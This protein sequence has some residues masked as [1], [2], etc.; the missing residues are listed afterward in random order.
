MAGLCG[1]VGDGT[2]DLHRVAAGL[3]WTG[4]EAT[5]AFDDGD[6]AVAG[7]FT[8]E[9]AA[10]QPVEVD[11]EAYLWV[12]GTIFGADLDGG[13][14]SRDRTAASTAAYCARLYEAHGP[15]FVA[16]LNGDF[17]LVIYRPDRGTL[18]IATDRLG[19][20]DAYYARPDDDTLVFSTAIQSLSRHPAV[21]PAF[22]ADYA[23][24]Y[25]ACR[26]RTFGVRTPLADTRM[27]HPGATTSI[28][29]AS[30]RLETDR[31]WVPR[32][33]PVDRPFSEF[34]EEFTERFEAAVADRL[35]PSR[36]HG[37]LL[38]GGADSRLVLAAMD[39][40]D[41]AHTTAFT[42]T[43]WMNREAR[44][45]ERV[46][47]TADV[48]FEWIRR[49]RDYH[50]RALERNP[51]LSNFVG[52]FNQAHAEGVM[53][54][55][56]PAVDE[57][58][59][60]SF[61]DTNVDGY[62]FPRRTVRLGPVGTIYLPAFE[63][64]DSVD[65]YVDTW[66]GDPPEYLADDVDVE[67]VLRREIRRTGDG[68]DHH[69]VT[70]GSPKELFVCGALAPRTNGTVLSLLHGLRQHVP[71]WSPFVDDRLVDLYLS[72]PTEYAAGRNVVHRAIERL[73][74]E[75]AG[76][77]YANTG[78]PIE[79]PFVAHF[80]GGMGLRF[81]RSYLPVA[82]PPEPHQ[83]QGSWPDLA[84]LIRETSFVRESIEGNE[85]TIRR[86]PF[87]DWEGVRE[88]YRDHLSGNDRQQDLYA[89]VTLLEM[90]VTGRVVE[91]SDRSAT[92]S[93]SGRD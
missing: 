22:D 62:S 75:L 9:A 63:P 25:L 90:P 49:D 57:V 80:L 48:D 18:A 5:T 15:G 35:H 68:I 42:V 78:V 69:G 67:A 64:M 6:V 2:Q 19:L 11:G 84:E 52:R 27:F 61:A 29:T 3:E 21:T 72:M 24:E 91:R 12:W 53:D 47:A 32:Y 33:R 37:L 59:T 1:V 50:A 17:L 51:A 34:V 8:D 55:I 82:E 38:S 16:G 10:D 86:L 36:E 44:T 89:L 83:T 31:Y 65:R 20:R 60:A 7:A 56:G 45:A 54:R 46:A 58:V 87:L 77:R 93:G 13:Y 43:G 41:R 81:T 73:D 76:V 92:G 66:T 70:Y 28:D 79:W 30:R 23:A 40:S 14:R 85:E 74:P 26:G 88:C 4:T 39:D 71:A